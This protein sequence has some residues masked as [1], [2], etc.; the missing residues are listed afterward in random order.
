MNLMIS[1]EICSGSVIS[2]TI[3]LSIYL[4]FKIGFIGYKALILVGLACGLGLLSK[5]TVL[6]VL[7]SLLLLLGLRFIARQ[8]TWKQIAT[9]IRMVSL[10]Y[11]WL[12][13]RTIIRFGDPF[14][15]NWDE[16][17]GVHYEQP[18]G[19][20]NIQF[21]T[22]FGS[23]FYHLPI[24]SRWVSF[25][26]DKYGSMWTD[27]HGTFLNL[28]DPTTQLLGSLSLWLALLPTLAITF[29][30]GCAIKFLSQHDGT[31]LTSL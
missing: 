31:T 10:T 18:L 23:V 2:G 12:Y 30:S 3:A 26:D 20:R 15:G 16:A 4:L 29:S 6:F 8:I 21:H 27:T 28:S 14:I 24:R 19:Y 13:G 7:L 17:S 25:W 1:N 9:I 11:G 5:Y 22:Q